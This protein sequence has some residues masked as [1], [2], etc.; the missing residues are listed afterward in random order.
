[1]L[2]GRQRPRNRQPD[3]VRAAALDGFNEEFAVLL[4]R[5]GA[6]L[7]EDVNLGEIGIDG[8]F[9]EQTKPH[10]GHLV[11]FDMLPGRGARQVNAR[12]NLMHMAGQPPQH[13]PRITGITG[14]SERMSP[15]PDEG[16]SGE[17]D[18]IRMPHGNFPGLGA[19]IGENQR[20][21]TA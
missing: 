8:F 16:V 13:V 19:C 7:V 1:M 12:D 15:V 4:Q 18:G 2:Q 14:F 9:V 6:G 21:D 20:G 5:I 10:A 11:E 3:H 17:H